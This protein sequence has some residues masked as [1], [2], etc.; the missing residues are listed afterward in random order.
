MF[1]VMP[2]PQIQGGGNSL[3][4]FSPVQRGLADYRQGEAEVYKSNMGRKIANSLAQGDYA[5]AQ[6]ATD[7]PS[8][9]VNIAGLKQRTELQ[10]A[11]LRHQRVQA[12]GGIAQMIDREADPAKRQA[13][14]QRFVG[15]DPR[16]ASLLP[17]TSRDAMTG[18]KYLMAEAA[19]YR[20]P[21][22]EQLQRSQ[23]AT[24]DIQRQAAGLDM[25]IKRR[26]LDNPS[27]KVTIV[28]DGGRAIL[29]DP[30]TGA[31]TELAGGGGKVSPGYRQQEN[32]N[33]QAIPGGP[34]DVKMSEKRQQD[35]ASMQQMFQSLDEL[36]KTANRVKAHPGLGGNFGMRGVVPNIPGSQA[37][38][39]W[40]IL[41]TLRTQA[42]FS[43]LQDMRNASKT[44]G[45]LG[46]ISDKEN[47]ML[48]S[49]LAPLQRAQSVEQAQRSADDILRYVEEAKA[50]IAGSYNDH[51]NNGG[52]ASRAPAG[53]QQFP[54]PQGPVKVSTPEE[55]ARLPSGTM[56]IGPDNKV[57]R[58]P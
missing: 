5:G 37:A 23:L 15:S 55:A 53:S 33:W 49:K 30:R 38:D 13:M 47:A 8:M 29:T 18:P 35:Y 52:A 21:L 9:A 16:I 46:A 17:E 43:A 14:W 26:E 12:I 4:D 42:G 57:R 25:Q 34:A 1:N 44:G 36:A 54:E 11:Q 27:G 3:I 56:F 50:R 28:P 22:H 2:L 10:D 24:A 40:A 39:A 51:W 19:G 58:V 6:A 45:A 32:G 41:E 31:V 20:D 48:Q 7:D